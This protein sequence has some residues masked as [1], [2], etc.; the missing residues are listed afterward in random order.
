M[1]AL[2]QFKEV[3]RKSWAHFAPL[4]SVTTPP[5]ALLARHAASGPASACWTWP[6]A[7]G[8]GHPTARAGARVAGLDLTPELIERARQNSRIAEVEVEWH[9]GDVEEL[10]FEDAT[11]DAVVSQ[12]GHMFAPRPEVAVSGVCAC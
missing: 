5:A 12:F 3:Q 6:A 9:V 1:D 8:R 4:E 11:F 7:R 10:P 2:A